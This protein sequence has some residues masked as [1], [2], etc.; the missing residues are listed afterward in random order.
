MVEADPHEQGSG[1]E[2]GELARLDLDLVRLVDGRRQARHAHPVAADRL[3]QGLEVRR[4]GD[5][6]QRAA[7][8]GGG[9]QQQEHGDED[10][11][12]P[13]AEVRAR[14][15]SVRMRLRVYFFA[16]KM[17]LG[18]MQCTPLRTSTTWLTRQSATIEASE[19]A[20]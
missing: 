18:T 15:E 11:Q 1:A 17:L 14:D 2:R 10:R 12:A 8:L 20:S 6:R 16:T 7:A 5:D 19:Y 3:H 9:G 13:T 4:R